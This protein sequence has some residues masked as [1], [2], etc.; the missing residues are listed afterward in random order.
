MGNGTRRAEREEWISVRKG[1]IVTGESDR[2]ES[3]PRRRGGA[4]RNR[5]KMWKVVVEM[6]SNALIMSANTTPARFPPYRAATSKTISTGAH[7]AL[8]TNAAVVHTIAVRR[9]HLRAKTIHDIGILSPSFSRSFHRLLLLNIFRTNMSSRW[10]GES[11]E[12]RRRSSTLG[13]SKWRHSPSA[14]ALSIERRPAERSRQKEPKGRER[15]FQTARE[16]RSSHYNHS[17]DSEISINR[18]RMQIVARS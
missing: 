9:Y 2:E 18:D 1:K 6:H 5:M 10:V 4:Q 13:S 3:V 11:P 12:R 7:P 16:S 15:R 14:G 8:R 17:S